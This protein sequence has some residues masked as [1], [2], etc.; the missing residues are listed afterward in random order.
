MLLA[1]SAWMEPGHSRVFL[2]LPDP[3]SIPENPVQHM[4]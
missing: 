1:S 3:S 2:V 4:S